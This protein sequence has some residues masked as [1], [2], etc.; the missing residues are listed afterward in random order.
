[1]VKNNRE[2]LLRIITVMQDIGD[3]F[4]QINLL[5]IVIHQQLLTGRLRLLDTE[6]L[7]P[8]HLDTILHRHNNKRFG[9]GNNHGMSVKSNG[10]EQSTRITIPQHSFQHSQQEITTTDHCI[11]TTITVR[12]GTNNNNNNNNDR[13]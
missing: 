8:R 7:L 13:M 10:D 3:D 5:L 1:M 6:Q 4:G 11:I 2:W 9:T 12:P